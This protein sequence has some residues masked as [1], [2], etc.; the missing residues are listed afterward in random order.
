MWP[1]LN[2]PPRK[3]LEETIQYFSSNGL[4][5]IGEASRSN[6]PDRMYPWDWKGGPHPPNPVTLY[7][8]HELIKV[9]KRITALEFGSGWSSLV[10]AHALQENKQLYEKEV[11]QLRRRNPFLL[12]V[13]EE[14]DSYLRI[15]R[16]RVL[17]AGLTNASFLLSDVQMSTRE[18]KF[19][20]LFDELPLINPD[21][22]YL[23]GP[24]Q[25][26]PK[27]KIRG[28]T[29]AHEEFMPMAADILQFEHFLSPGTIILCDGRAANVRFLRRNFQRDWEYIRNE[30][31]DQHVLH[32]SEEDSG[33]I[34][35]QQLKFYQEPV[36]P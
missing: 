3:D 30:E 21:I 2:L 1:K 17:G 14:N 35:R 5:Q 26:A 6:R 29:T 19:V 27:H 25:F 11:S 28:L 10:I 4:G 20:T 18:G 23:D 31:S 8:L 36:G 34:N 16:D 12:S 15:S 33:F 9:N 7:Y 22:I 32:L 24:S 13:V